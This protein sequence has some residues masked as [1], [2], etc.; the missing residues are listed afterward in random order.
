[1]DEKKFDSPEK[2]FRQLNAHGLL[3]K[4]SRTGQSEVINTRIDDKQLNTVST[5]YR[6]VRVADQVSR[7]RP[8]G[9]RKLRQPQ[10][11]R[12][13]FNNTRLGVHEKESRFS[14]NEGHT[15]REQSDAS[16][17][18]E[19]LYTTRQTRIKVEHW[20]FGGGEE[21]SRSKFT[22]GKKHPSRLKFEEDR[23]GERVRPSV[24]L[25]VSDGVTGDTPTITGSGK[26]TGTDSLF[27]TV[28]R[29]E[30]DRNLDS[31][32]QKSENQ[33]VEGVNAERK[34][35]SRGARYG[36]RF[37][38]QW[39]DG[40][41]ERA[42]RREVKRQ[43]KQLLRDLKEQHY[44]L[45]HGRP[46]PAAKRR[47]AIEGYRK[48]A[49]AR[50]EQKIGV[51]ATAKLEKVMA[52]VA[53]KGAAVIRAAVVYIGAPLLGIVLTFMLIALLAAAFFGSIQ[54]TAITVLTSYTAENTT[55]EAASSHYS[56][57]EAE[58][59]KMIKDIPTEWRWQH[60]D[61]FHYYLDDIEHDPYQLMAYLSV[62]YP[63]FEFS[64]V[65]TEL[66]YI[67]HERYTLTLDEWSETRGT[68]PDEYTYYHLDV[69]LRAKPLEPILLQELARDTEN[70]LL[71]W[72]D[73]LIETKGARQAYANPFDIDWSGKV[74]SLYG[75]RVDPI[76][77]REL[78]RHRG[79]DIAMPR[80]TPIKAG[81][82]GTVRHVGY[83]SIMGNY[84]ILDTD[85]VEQTIKYG[86][87]DS[88]RVSAGDK[89]VAGETVIGTVGNSGQSTGPH[90]H[91][92]ILENG[93]YIN[94]I[95]SLEFR[96]PRTS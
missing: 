72:Y 84:I 27:H 66:D 10:Q 81:V 42:S 57:L 82:T 89:V 77:G 8:E 51:E 60:I 52:F 26:A 19:T 94:P 68:E 30:T 37:G 73:V 36:L 67:F 39:Q 65:K 32:A 87:C 92:E 62:K 1:M 20:R 88:V 85:G 33:A 78:Q 3:K 75:Y 24:G 35:A 22:D 54:N 76:G 95:Y 2:Q 70:D 50:V 55:I 83:D 44:E 31:L 46:S 71:S 59:D 47:Q 23:I 90:L 17:D 40:H 25:S 9:K 45:T 96:E 74:S 12:L 21:K 7:L 41:G 86:H 91:V 13:K 80:G 29:H 79:L 18:S 43:N 11:S 15:F 69:T 63:G 14:R 48:Q 49:R 4:S 5:T 64:D 28:L 61:A 53:E 38:R 58:L 16:T 34:L 6:L 56:K 93:E